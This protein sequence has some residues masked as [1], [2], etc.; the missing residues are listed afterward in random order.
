MTALGLLV[1][2]A[3]GIGNAPA[4]PQDCAYVMTAVVYQPAP[5]V[6]KS[7]RFKDGGCIVM[8]NL[9][10]R[11]TL[12]QRDVCQLGAHEGGHL[13]G[14]VHSQDPADVMFSPFLP[15]ARDYC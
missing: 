6:A 1:A 14:L 15:L 8:L 2:L 12:D 5:M 4:P 11:V 9:R 3:A 13:G 7:N 10:Y